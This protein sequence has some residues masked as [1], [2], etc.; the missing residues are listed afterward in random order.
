VAEAASRETWENLSSNV[1]IVS[2]YLLFMLM[3]SQQG[4]FQ[5]KR[6]L[7]AWAM[8]PQSPSNRYGFGFWLEDVNRQRHNH[9]V[10]RS[11]VV[12]L[13]AAL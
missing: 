1:S 6:V 4:V 3:I 5:G 8:G 12:R 7:S 13:D 11:R 10:Q 2:D 9:S